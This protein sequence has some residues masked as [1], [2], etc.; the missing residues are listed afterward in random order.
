MDHDRAVL[1]TV[2]SH[3]LQFKA[4][5]QLEIKLNGSALPGTSDAVYQMEVDLRA[6]E[7][8][9]SL[10]DHVRK[11]QLIQRSLQSGGSHLPVLIAS[12]GILGT[13]GQL[14]MVLET[15]Q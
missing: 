9:V 13:G 3:I 1:L 5:G 14:H 15:K 10:V 6:V 7:R 4:L 8:S 2:R 11:A 12:H